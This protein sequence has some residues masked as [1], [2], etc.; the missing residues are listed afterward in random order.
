MEHVTLDEARARL[1][2]LLAAAAEGATVIIEGADKAEFQLLPLERGDPDTGRDGLWYHRARGRVLD[3]Q[4]G[5]VYYPD[6]PEAPREPLQPGS[7][8]GL[9]TIAEDFDAPLEDFRAYM[10]PGSPRP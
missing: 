10:Q 2:D 6:V 1:A 3:E 5:L 7:A 9:L 8:A 4:A